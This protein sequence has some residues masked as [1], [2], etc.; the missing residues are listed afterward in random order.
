VRDLLSQKCDDIVAHENPRLT[1]ARAG[2]LAAT[3]I[4]QDS[5]AFRVKQGSGIVGVKCYVLM[6]DR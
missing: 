5:L 4:L 2:Q 1:N 6:H 3:G